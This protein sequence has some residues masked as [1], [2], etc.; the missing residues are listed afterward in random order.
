MALRSG[1]SETASDP[2]RIASV[3][4]LGLAT[5]PQSRWSRPM[6]IGAETSPSRTISLKRR[7]GAVALAVAEPADARGQALEGD[8]LAG[9]R[10]QLCRRSS[11]GKSSSRAP[12]GLAMSAGSP[13]SATQ[14]KG[15]R[16]SQNEG[17]MNAGT[18]PGKSKASST[19]GRLGAWREVVAVVEGDGAARC[20]SRM[21]R[22]WSAIDASTAP[23][24]AS[25]RPRAA[26]AASS[27]GQAVGDVAVARVV[28]AG[29]VGDD[30]GREAALAQ[31]GQH[32]GG[33]AEQADRHGPALGL[34]RR[35][36]RSIASSSESATSSR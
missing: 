6:T 33:V 29:L 14:R 5:E 27:R 1:Q 8:P 13:E 12:V 15:P 21:A 2:S 35:G 34:G 23:C 4:R 31:L 16:P 18:K 24:S 36:A 9:Q 17:R 32:L 28:G 30:V 22:T 19:P 11:S 25:G 10:S 20:S 7:A 3:S 26:R